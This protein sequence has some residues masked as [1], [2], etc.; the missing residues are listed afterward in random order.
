MGS[1]DEDEKDV[2][3]EWKKRGRKAKRGERER[4]GRCIKWREVARSTWEE[5]K[6]KQR[7]RDREEKKGKKSQ[8]SAGGGGR[9]KRKGKRGGVEVLG[10]LVV[11]RGA[12]IQGNGLF[13]I[14]Q[15]T[16]PTHTHT[17]EAPTWPH[18]SSILTRPHT[19]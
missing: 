5:R 18:D 3:K 1:R 13:L 9:K 16:P 7:G 12:G 6:K 4:E 11:G 19:H 14:I 2:D 8:V 15:T 17:E 10:V